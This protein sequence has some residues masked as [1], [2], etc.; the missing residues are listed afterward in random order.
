[1]ML[2]DLYTVLQGSKRFKIQARNENGTI[3][4]LDE[5]LPYEIRYLPAGI[6]KKEVLRI[7]LDEGI[8]FLQ[9]SSE[10]DEDWSK[11]D[12]NRFLDVCEDEDLI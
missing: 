12:R 2:K 1:M 3:E 5:I 9:G 11:V 7:D 8:I 6:T 4:T 10:T